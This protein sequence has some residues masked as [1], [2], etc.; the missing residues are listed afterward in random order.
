[1]TERET[2]PPWVA[3]CV[4]RFSRDKTVPGKVLAEVV[5]RG[6]VIDAGWFTS[7]VAARRWFAEGY[8]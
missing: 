4:L 2:L 6:R 3:E 8:Q 7:R 5:F 1:M